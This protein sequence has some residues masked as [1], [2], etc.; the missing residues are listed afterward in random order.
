MSINIILYYSLPAFIFAVVVGFLLY[1]PSDD[2]AIKIKESSHQKKS[3]FLHLIQIL[4]F[5]IGLYFLAYY[6]MLLVFHI[7]AAVLLIF[8]QLFV[9]T[10]DVSNLSQFTN[11]VSWFAYV[12]AILSVVFNVKNIEKYALKDLIFTRSKKNPSLITVLLKGNGC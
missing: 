7:I 1:N 8:A 5:A 11:S 9:K 10:V 2:A 6:A 4:L 3:L 12:F